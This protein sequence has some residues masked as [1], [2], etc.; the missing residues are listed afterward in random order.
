M[1]KKKSLK[2]IGIEGVQ[3][4]GL[5]VA[6]GKLSNRKILRKQ[7]RATLDLRQRETAPVKQSGFKTEEIAMGGFL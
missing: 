5:K 1:V 2:T 7:T 4:I 3:R 6:G